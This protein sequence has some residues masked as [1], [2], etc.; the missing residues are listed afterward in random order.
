ML[1]ILRY[2][3]GR[4]LTPF[5]FSRKAEIRDSVLSGGSRV[6]RRPAWTRR[7]TALLLQPGSTVTVTENYVSGGIAGV[8]V[9]LA[10][11]AGAVSGNTIVGN[12]ST[13]ALVAADGAMSFN[14]NNVFVGGGSGTG[15]YFS[16]A[17][18]STAVQDNTI[19]FA[20]T[21]IELNCQATN[22]KVYSN[23]ILYAAI[24]VDK[25]LLGASSPNT[26]ID[27]AKQTTSCGMG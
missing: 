10:G 21:G 19:V 2:A 27:V 7:V 15:V 1:R 26:Y 22:G 6:S 14:S 4:S 5:L 18:S 11:A 23:T 9:Q 17:T 25:L 8:G 13:G 20:D 12:G 16:T 24:G 3:K